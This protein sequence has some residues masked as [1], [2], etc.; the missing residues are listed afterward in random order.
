MS[1]PAPSARRLEPAEDEPLQASLLLQVLPYSNL[2]N[3]VE[4]GDVV[5]YTAYSVIRRA[6]L[7]GSN[8][9]MAV[10]TSLS[11]DVTAHSVLSMK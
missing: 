5:A 6:R 9:G 2:N 1:R 3:D 4:G 10:K 11:I 8:K 7:R